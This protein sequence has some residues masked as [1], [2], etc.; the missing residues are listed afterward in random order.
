MR[1]A[2]RL[3]KD[4]YIQVFRRKSGSAEALSVSKS[5]PHRLRPLAPELG[6]HLLRFCGIVGRRR[7]IVVLMETALLCERQK[8]RTAHSNSLFPFLLS[9][10]VWTLA[11]HES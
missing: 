3:L 4:T 6:K 10:L 8:I 1:E 7:V 11:L 5:L 9:W 2:L